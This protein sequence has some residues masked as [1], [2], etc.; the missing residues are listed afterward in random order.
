MYNKISKRKK[1]FKRLTWVSVKTFNRMVEIVREAEL[2][3]LSWET[4]W[5]GSKLSIENQVL[6]CLWYL[7]V[8]TTQFY[9]W[10]VMWIAESNVCRITK[11]IE[12]ILME[13]WEFSLPS[14]KELYNWDFEVLLVDATESPIQRPK[15]KQK[16]SYSGKKKRHTQKAQILLSEELKI[17][18]VDVAK[19][20]VHDKKIFDRSKLPITKESE[21]LADS[22]Y[23]WIQH[24]HQKTTLP[25]KKSKKNPLTKEDK[26]RNKE[27]AKKR[28]YVEHV[29][30]KLK[31][32][33][34]LALPYRNRRK[35]YWLRLNLISWI[36]NYENF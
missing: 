6:L 1:I 15:K 34:I 27:K 8:Y 5:R 25:K 17:L 9:L 7:R 3:R 19:W 11:K 2:E 10:V 20:R 24:E 29:I 14:K 33:Q 35:R 31:I 4:R 28:I 13:S 16:K 18:R 23:Q 36:Y 32:F 22:W 21:L 30:G 26:K 12:N